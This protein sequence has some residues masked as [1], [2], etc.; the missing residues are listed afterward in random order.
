MAWKD[1]NPRER[2][3]AVSFDIMRDVE[4]SLLGGTTQIGNVIMCDDDVCTTAMTDGCDVWYNNQLVM[5]NTR[6]QLRFVVAHENLHKSLMH[7]TEYVTA[8][9]RFPQYAGMACDYVVNLLVEELDKG[10]GFT[11]WTTD[12]PPLID[13]KYTGKSMLEVLQDLIKNP[14]PPPPQGGGVTLDK[15]IMGRK[16]DGKNS[17]GMTDEQIQKLKQDVQDAVAQG[18]IVRDKLQARE[19]GSSGSGGRFDAL[20]QQR[21]TD[22]KGP[23]RRL[24]QQAVEGDDVSK[25]S[26]PNKRFLPLGIVMPSH[27]AEAAGP[28]IVAVDTSGS[29]SSS[30]G[31]LLGEVSR[32]AE[33]VQPSSLQVIWWDS[34]VA[35]VQNFTKENYG[36]LRTLLKPA[37]G[38]GTVC[39]VVA[40]YIAEKKL[41]P[42]VVLYI[43]DGFIEGSPRVPKQ[44]CV[45]AVLDNP[46]WV[47]PKGKVLHINSVEL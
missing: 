2:I 13:K 21:T 46:N 24:L 9:E 29:L 20:N 18:Q 16:G 44:P 1:L 19:R 31:I 4:F 43:T 12:P 45:W 14:P 17:N 23:L 40:D 38:G 22:W 47:P 30:Y 27:Y 41:K 34:A 36:A 8:F 35:G 33:Q 6:E 28:V 25:F 42:S 7:C 37:G 5:N 3:T 32:I 39:S 10:R 15:H 11:Q 26:P